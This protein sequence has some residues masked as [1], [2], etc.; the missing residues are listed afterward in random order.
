MTRFATNV[1]FALIFIVAGA[2]AS[3]LFCLL[4]FKL[5]AFGYD[6]INIPFLDGLDYSL[7]EQLQFGTFFVTWTGFTLLLFWK[8]YKLDYRWD[9]GKYLR[10]LRCGYDLRGNQSNKCPECGYKMTSIQQDELSTKDA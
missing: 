1:G 7:V 3:S 6:V 9:S 2:I 10:C 8:K 5:F 4:I